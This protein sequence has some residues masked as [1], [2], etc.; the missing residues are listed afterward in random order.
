MDLRFYPSIELEAMLFGICK[1]SISRDIQCTPDYECRGDLYIGPVG[2]VNLNERNLIRS[3]N[4]FSNFMGPTYYYDREEEY[5][6]TKEG[7]MISRFYARILLNKEI[8]IGLDLPLILSP[9]EEFINRSTGEVFA[10]FKLDLFTIWADKFGEI[11]MPLYLAA[12]KNELVSGSYILEEYIKKS[13]K[14]LH[15][16]IDFILREIIPN[17]RGIEE[18]NL[19]KLS[20]LNFINRSSFALKE[21]ERASVE[22]IFRH[23]K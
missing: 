3:G 7:D 15:S 20:I 22:A 19:H 18:L 5:V 13:I 1:G 11:P 21:E 9:Y 6:N 12:V 14:Y 17:N 2:I 8:R 23:L 10:S 16:N 4:V